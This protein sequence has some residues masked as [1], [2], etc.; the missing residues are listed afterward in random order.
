MTFQTL[1]GTGSEDFTSDVDSERSFDEQ[2]FIAFFQDIHSKEESRYDHGQTSLRYTINKI[3]ELIAILVF[4]GTEPEMQPD[5]ERPASSGEEAGT[6]THTAEHDNDI[7][8]FED[9]VDHRRKV[10]VSLY[11]S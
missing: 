5:G 6:P 9:S 8:A 11:N 4:V 3:K 2:N 7:S 10:R 1:E